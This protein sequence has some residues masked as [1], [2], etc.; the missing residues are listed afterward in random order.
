MVL[1]HPGFSRAFSV[2]YYNNNYSFECIL[3]TKYFLYAT[4]NSLTINFLKF[5]PLFKQAKQARHRACQSH[6]GTRWGAGISNPPHPSLFYHEIRT[7]QKMYPDI[8]SKYMVSAVY[9]I[10][11]I[12][13]ELHIAICYWQKPFMCCKLILRSGI[14]VNASFRDT[15]WTLDDYCG[16]SW[17]P[18]IWS[19]LGTLCVPLLA[20][21][22]PLVYPLPEFYS[23]GSDSWLLIDNLLCIQVHIVEMG[24]RKR[25]L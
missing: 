25:S 17:S 13:P 5:S 15:N 19:V 7:S 1:I 3:S 24:M 20:L 11:T 18:G 2:S 8:G 6:V 21:A 14:W 12:S 23:A 22:Y 9:C 4:Y 16:N 10:V